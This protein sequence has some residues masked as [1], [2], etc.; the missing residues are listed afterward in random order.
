MSAGPRN[1][2]VHP[3]VAHRPEELRRMADALRRLTQATVTN[4]ASAERTDSLA[5]QVEEIA[6]EVQACIP[7]TPPPRIKHAPEKDMRRYTHAPFDPV[8]G[9]WNPVAA[10]VEA[11]VDGD[12][13]LGVATYGHAHEGPPGLVHGAIIA[14]AFDMLLALGN[15]AVSRSGP[16][17]NLC[18]RYHRPTRVGEVSTYHAKQDRV[19][20]RKLH[21]TGTLEQDGEVTASSTGLFLYVDPVM[22]GDL[23]KKQAQRADTATDATPALAPDDTSLP[24]TTHPAIV[25]RA[26]ELARLADAVRSLQL[27]TVLHDA[28]ADQTVRWA[29]VIERLSAELETTVPADIPG[30]FGGWVGSFDPNALF[31]YDCVFGRF[32]PIAPPLVAR[33]TDGVARAVGA[34]D[35]RFEGPPNAVH[36]GMLAAIFDQVCN[37]A[38]IGAEV[39]GLTTELCIS[40]RA[41]TRIE[42]P[43][44]FEAEVTEVTDKTV[45]TTARSFQ[46]GTVTCEATGTFRRIP[47]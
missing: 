39:P 47:S 26:T 7:A 14:G 43:T 35:R 27:A 11:Y 32:N 1:R 40:Y 25:G 28:T 31:V 18:V 3:L 38:N 23:T 46:D 36:G 5:A 6:D 45:T 44:V 4:T 12:A 9:P 17:L 29:Q 30:R 10:P 41:F 2:T 15:S 34:L 19:D 42:H 16:T 24:A 21:T 37:V 13:G 8:V 20:G 33:F 22:I